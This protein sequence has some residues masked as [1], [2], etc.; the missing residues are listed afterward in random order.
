MIAPVIGSNRSPQSALKCKDP[1]RRGIISRK[2]V[3][4]HTRNGE[5]IASPHCIMAAAILRRSVLSFVGFFG[6]ALEG[7]VVLFEIDKLP[8]ASVALYELAVLWVQVELCSII[9][10]PFS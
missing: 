1:N 8:G 5:A 3:Q 7:L 2:D 9:D 6:H 4:K 10:R